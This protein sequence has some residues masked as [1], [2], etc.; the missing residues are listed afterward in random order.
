MSCPLAV[1]Q[2]GRTAVVTSETLCLC[3]PCL[4]CNAFTGPRSAYQDSVHI[5]SQSATLANYK[6]EVSMVLQGKRQRVQ[7][8]EI[9]S[10]GPVS[11]SLAT[12][13]RLCLLMAILTFSPL[14][15][16][17]AACNISF[18][19]NHCTPAKQAH[20]LHRPCLKGIHD[21]KSKA[22]HASLKGS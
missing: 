8:R 18:N 19:D 12:A 9:P 20:G 7:Q 3:W 13:Q 22:R 1:S 6:S 4:M 17:T 2:R 5:D 16:A 21:A 15:Q 10:A 11:L 14:R